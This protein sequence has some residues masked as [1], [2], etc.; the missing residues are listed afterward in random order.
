MLL[1]G[2]QFRDLLSHLYHSAVLDPGDLQV[3]GFDDIGLGTSCYCAHGHILL[4]RCL[5]V[6]NLVSLFK[7]EMCWKGGLV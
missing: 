3:I 6:P 7:L 5:L 1:L 2:L 4:L